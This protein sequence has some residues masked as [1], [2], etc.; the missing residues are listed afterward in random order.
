MRRASPRVLCERA[1]RGGAAR[2]SPHLGA[3]PVA[4]HA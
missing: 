2:A 4:V 1:A 3:L